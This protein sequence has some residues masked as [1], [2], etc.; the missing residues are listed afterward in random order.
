MSGK[1]LRSQDLLHTWGACEVSTGP[2]SHCRLI[3]LRLAGPVSWTPERTMMCLPGHHQKNNSNKKGKKPNRAVIGLGLLSQ[4][5]KWSLCKVEKQCFAFPL[6]SKASA[7]SPQPP[8]PMPRSENPA[9]TPSRWT[10]AARP[11]HSRAVAIQL[12]HNLFL[13]HVQ[14]GSGTV[15]GQCRR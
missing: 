13:D 9:P 14:L 15:L 2:G 5:P 11:T 8:T 4:L 12:T 6:D 10:A 7:S 3:R 1:G